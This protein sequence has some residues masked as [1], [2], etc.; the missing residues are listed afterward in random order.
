MSRSGQRPPYPRAP[1]TFNPCPQY[2]SSRPCRGSTATML[3]RAKNSPEQ[4]RQGGSAESTASSQFRSHPDAL[5]TRNRWLSSAGI[6]VA[7]LLERQNRLSFQTERDC[8]SQS[9]RFHSG[10]HLRILPRQL[11]RE[12][13]IRLGPEAKGKKLTAELEVKI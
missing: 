1:E 10:R 4:V 2:L 6:A 9:K 12:R 8:P 5:P 11:L 7:C 13:P 3:F